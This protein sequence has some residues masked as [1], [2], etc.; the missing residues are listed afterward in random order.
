VGAV[1]SCA[2]VP[3]DRTM[4]RGISN[5][6]SDIVQICSSKRGPKLIDF[7]VERPFLRILFH[8]SKIC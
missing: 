3:F 5:R 1:Q 2:K 6:M 8:L 4:K 7:T